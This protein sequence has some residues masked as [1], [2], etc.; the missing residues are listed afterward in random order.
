MPGTNSVPT[1]T[2]ASSV[3][4]NS[5]NFLLGS[6]FALSKWPLRGKVVF[7]NF[8]CP[9]PTW[10]ELMPSFS[11]VFTCITLQLSRYNTVQGQRFP[12]SSKMATMPTF[13]ANAPVRLDSGVHVLL[14]SS[15]DISSTCSAADADVKYLKHVPL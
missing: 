15:T 6:T 2:S 9:I 5:H 3:T 8:L 4:R 1:G 12:H 10:I 11:G 13:N 7:F 14:L